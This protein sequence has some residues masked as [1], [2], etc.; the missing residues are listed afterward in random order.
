MNYL[1]SYLLIL[2]ST[3]AIILHNHYDEGI[4]LSELLGCGW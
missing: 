3:L 1:W 2:N 4:L